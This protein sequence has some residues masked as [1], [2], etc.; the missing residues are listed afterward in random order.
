MCVFCNVKASQVIHET[1]NSRVI[2]DRYPVTQLHTLVMPKRHVA[3]IFE[4]SPAEVEDMLQE[5]SWAR[6]FVLKIDST[7]RSF[8]V[9]VNDG[10]EAGQTIP[11]CH[12]H[13]IPRRQGDVFDPRG[14]VRGV[15]PSKQKY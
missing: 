14:G 2:F 13:V 15:I 6:Q 12:I 11:H 10:P 8:N 5:V 1:E 3:S 9:G 7:I 4:L